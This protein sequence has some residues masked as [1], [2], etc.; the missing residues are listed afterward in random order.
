M[1]YYEPHD[2]PDDPYRVAPPYQASGEIEPRK[3]T[4]AEIAEM[5]SEVEMEIVES[6]AHGHDFTYYTETG[7]MERWTY[8]S[9]YDVLLNELNIH[10]MAET[11]AAL[12]A[13]GMNAHGGKYAFAVR[14]TLYRKA[15]T[16]FVEEQ[17]LRRLDAAIAQEAQ[18][19]GQEE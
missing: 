10:E 12:M 18:S 3:P 6:L 8:E 14:V 17:A 2:M 11:M 5:Q 19:V 1:P 9:L 4:K 13:F 7:F 16:P 15:I